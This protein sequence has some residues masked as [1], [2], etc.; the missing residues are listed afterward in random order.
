MGNKRRRYPLLFPT[1]TAAAPL[2][3]QSGTHGTFHGRR[4]FGETDARLNEL[5]ERHPRRT[6]G[7][8]H[9]RRGLEEE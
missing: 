1:K 7:S 4:N 9:D 2:A 3:T 5:R 6:G 8:T